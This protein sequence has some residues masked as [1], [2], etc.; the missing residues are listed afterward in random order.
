[1]HDRHS[2]QMSENSASSLQRASMGSGD[3]EPAKDGRESLAA[4]LGSGS[5]RWSI[6]P[7]PARLLDTCRLAIP[8]VALLVFMCS[9]TVP[10]QHG[11][12]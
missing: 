5:G 2:V 12:L 3:S 7:N 9:C 10:S 1:M 4:R 6:L 11:T 8:L